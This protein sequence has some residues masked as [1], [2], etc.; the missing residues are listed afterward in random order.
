MNNA[1][2]ILQDHYFDRVSSHTCASD[3]D[4]L[5]SN[6]SASYDDANRVSKTQ[7]SSL[8]WYEL[9]IGQP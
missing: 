2:L 4:C 6:A 5:R 7:S 9:E 8:V 3:F 1:D